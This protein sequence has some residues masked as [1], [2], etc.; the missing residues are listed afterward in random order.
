[1]FRIFVYITPMFPGFRNRR[2]ALFAAPI[3]LFAL[4]SCCLSGLVTTLE[5]RPRI[6]E[7]FIER[8]PLGFPSPVTHVL[9]TALGGRIELALLDPRRRLAERP[10]E[11]VRLLG[12]LAS[13]QTV[14]EVPLLRIDEVLSAGWVRPERPECS[15]SPTEWR[16]CADSHF[17]NAME[18]PWP[19]TGFVPYRIF[20]FDGDGVADDVDA[21]PEN[22]NETTDTDGDGVGNNADSD[23]DGDG[24]PDIYERTHGLLPLVDDGDW[25]L[26]GDGMTN[27][28][29]YLAGTAVDDPNSLLRVERFV[30]NWPFSVR[31]LWQSIPGRLYRVLAAGGPDGRF[32]Q[33]SEDME[34][35]DK[36]TSIEIQIE[37]RSAAAFY[38][39][40]TV[41]KK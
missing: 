18:P 32:V 29:E 20:D 10:L 27:R 13:D 28:D 41:I 12:E 14:N 30:V 21:F 3:L 1:M 5:A 31:L 7:G 36:F 34:A 15:F 37:R 16:G 26:D 39:I 40:E 19:E 24:I 4:V 6:V 35:T 8:A 11:R 17:A 25:D 9:R 2:H 38:Q 23:D 22:P 33:V